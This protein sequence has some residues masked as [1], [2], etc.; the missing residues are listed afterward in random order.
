M[1]Q[2]AI[3]GGA[4]T[5][6]QGDHR[7]W[8]QLGA[9]E[10]EAVS[11]VLE[12]GVLGGE[13]G[14]ASRALEARFAELVGVRHALLTHAGTSALQLA[15]AAAEIA[16]G[17]EVILPAYGYVAAPLCVLARGGIPRFVDVDRESG[18]LDPRAVEEVLTPRARAIVPMHI[19]G[20]PADMDRLGALAA[21]YGL[22]LI[23]DAAQALGATHRGR[24]VGGLGASAAFSFQSTKHVPAGEGGVFVTDDDAAAERARS[25]RGFG[26]DVRAQR[27][28]GGLVAHTLGG[29]GRGNEM[30]A[31]VALAQLE[32]LPERM[33]TMRWNETLL[34]DAFADL[35]GLSLQTVEADRTAV[36]Y[37]LR[38]HFDA[39]V[40]GLALAPRALRSLLMRALLA[41]GVGVTLWQDHLLPEHPA[42]APHGGFERR[43]PYA[44]HPE[45]DTLRAEYRAERF[46]RARALLDAS[47]V[48]FDENRPLIA[49]TPRTVERVAAAV[50]KVWAGRHALARAFPD[51]GPTDR[52]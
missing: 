20:C 50:R 45:P 28:A 42:F 35:E 40:A 16:P 39:R 48:L 8:P 13:D 11:R 30:M 3:L 21:R 37:K 43:W 7:P 22:A 29:V 46:P 34:R 38:L 49:Q 32:R 23:E 15:L 6:T 5:L 19:H 52:T 2:L 25:A 18:N 51:D 44:L 27:E 47:L 41:E 36:W 1:S 10:R 4:P 17:E 33:A 31:A 26:R 14:P 12:R 9:R 24:P